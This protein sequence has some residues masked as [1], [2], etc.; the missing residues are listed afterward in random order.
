MYADLTA[1]NSRLNCV[2][3]SS[4]PPISGGSSIVSCVNLVSRCSSARITLLIR[5][6]AYPG[7]GHARAVVYGRR[8]RFILWMR[9][10]SKR[11]AAVL[12]FAQRARDDLGQRRQRLLGAAERVEERV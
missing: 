5:P 8:V 6:R 10:H 3:M 4:L 1:P 12:A 7:S 9:V 2:C 11:K